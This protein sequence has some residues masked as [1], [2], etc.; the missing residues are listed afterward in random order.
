VIG[1]FPVGPD[2]PKEV[3]TK[4]LAVPAIL[5][6]RR[7]CPSCPKGASNSRAG[8]RHRL[9]DRPVK[10]L[11]ESQATVLVEFS[12]QGGRLFRFVMSIGV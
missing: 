7:R 3:D 1:R 5:K 10:A 8:D 12:Q 11:C 6:T 4:G 9:E 2:A